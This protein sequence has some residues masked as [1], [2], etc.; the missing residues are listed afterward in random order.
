MEWVELENS[1]E[2]LAPSYREHVMLLCKDR[3]DCDFAAS[4]AITEALR[5]G[6]LCI[7]AS[8]HNGDSTHLAQMSSNIPNFREHMKCGDL[9]IIDF[10]PFADCALKS[11]LTPFIG[12]IRHIEGLIVER[13]HKGKSNKVMIFAEA[14]GE[15]AA[16]HHFQR[17]FD[18]EKW[19]HDVHAQWMTKKLHISL[20]CPHFG[21]I[22]NAPAALIAKDHISR[23]HTLTLELS[24]LQ[25]KRA[26]KVDMRILV[27][28]PEDDIRQVYQSY[29]DKLSGFS[30][31]T[32]ETGKSA[33]ERV[34]SNSEMFDLVIVDAHLRDISAIEVA[35]QMVSAI[36]DQR[37]AF[38]TTTSVA[39]LKAEI[40]S[41]RLNSEEILEKPFTFTKLLGLVSKEEAVKKKIN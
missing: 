1:V 14:A 33:L 3:K 20:I 32:C 37:I 29:F 6:L 39:Q 34:R 31:S 23:V 36:P 8:V 30:I 38:T 16:N 21:P 40:R 15:L 35:R 22:L 41:I 11:N 26:S 25:Q 13:V 28:E 12:L 24:R 10:K 18:L 7:Y 4:E 5:D 17:S 9:V 19:W 2:L 27:V